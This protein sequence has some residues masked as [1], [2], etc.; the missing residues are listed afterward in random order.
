MQM[1]TYTKVSGEKTRLMAKES[2]SMQMELTMRVNGLM[3]SNMEWASNVG[4]MELNTKGS[5]F[6]DKSKAMVS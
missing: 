2:I 6:K 4:L 1:V 5:S 3:T